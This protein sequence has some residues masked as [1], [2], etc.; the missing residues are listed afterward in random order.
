MSD[1]NKR[2]EIDAEQYE[3]ETFGRFGANL[4][5]NANELSGTVLDA[6]G[7]GADEAGDKRREMAKDYENHFLFPNRYYIPEDQIDEYRDSSAKEAQKLL[8]WGGI[9]Q[10]GLKM[11]LK[12][13]APEAQMALREEVFNAPMRKGLEAAKG[14]IATQRQGLSD[15]EGKI[16]QK[17]EDRIPL[18]KMGEQ[19]DPDQ[20]AF[21]Q[22]LQFFKGT[23][24][25]R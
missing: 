10:Q 20:E 19:P 22:L 11:Y 8:P 17:L 3:P 23:Q 21:A 2:Y 1:K 14:R 18:T 13:M 4:W 25:L 15:I 7:M 12:K 24:G 5:N 16:A 9:E 6:I